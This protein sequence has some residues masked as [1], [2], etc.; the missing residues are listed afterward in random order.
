MTHDQ[1]QIFEAFERNQVNGSVDQ[2]ID[3]NNFE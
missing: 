2:L 3:N 1:I